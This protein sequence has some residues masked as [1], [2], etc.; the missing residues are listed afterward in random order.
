MWMMARKEEEERRGNENGT[1]TRW[2]SLP[3]PET[4]KSSVGGSGVSLFGTPTSFE[5][6][7]GRASGDG[8]FL[9][10]DI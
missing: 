3:P 4:R 10:Q 1:V 6:P 9:I 5:A 8:G 7:R 2:G